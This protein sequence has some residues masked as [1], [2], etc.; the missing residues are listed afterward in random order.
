MA[1]SFDEQERPALNA[2][3]LFV[4][5]RAI[6]ALIVS[7]PDPAAFARA[8]GQITASAQVDHMSVAG[9]DRFRREATDFARELLDLAH[10]EIARRNKPQA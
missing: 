2:T 3:R 4:L 8:F 10:D 9:T 5:Q 1:E 6:A 7:H